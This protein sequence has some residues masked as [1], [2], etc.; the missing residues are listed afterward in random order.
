MIFAHLRKTAD[1]ANARPLASP[2]ARPLAVLQIRLARSVLKSN[3]WLAEIKDAAALLRAGG[4]F[5]PV[6][7]K[8]IAYCI[9]FTLYRKALP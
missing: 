1:A 3:F 4:V 7:G 5:V 2:L 9:K 8:S 6:L